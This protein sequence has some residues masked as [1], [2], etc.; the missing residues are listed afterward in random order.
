MSD[1]IEQALSMIN[2]TR[3]KLRAAHHL[4]ETANALL[5]VV[6]KRLKEIEQ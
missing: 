6:E 1:K 4:I 3:K 2:T 5:D